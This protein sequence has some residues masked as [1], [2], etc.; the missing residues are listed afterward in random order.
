MPRHVQEARGG[1]TRVWRG[2]CALPVSEMPQVPSLVELTQAFVAAFISIERS[3]FR[4]SVRTYLP[5]GQRA[6]ADLAVSHR[7]DARNVCQRRKAVARAKTSQGRRQVRPT[8]RMQSSI[9]WI[10]LLTRARLF[11]PESLLGRTWRSEGR[12]VRRHLSPDGVP[13]CAQPPLLLAYRSTPRSRC[14]SRLSKC[15]LGQ[16]LAPLSLIPSDQL[17]P[18]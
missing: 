5:I 3:I 12:C 6:L 8:W 15:K 13:L 2:Q 16:S 9:T 7:F 4:M 1:C 11:H 17:M 18:A 14:W 10:A